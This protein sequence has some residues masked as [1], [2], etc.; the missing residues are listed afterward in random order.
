MD[1]FLC[2]VQC[3]EL[4]VPTNEDWAD[5]QAWLDEQEAKWPMELVDSSENYSVE[6]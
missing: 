6:A 5:Y 1:D 4:Y 3:D 2:E